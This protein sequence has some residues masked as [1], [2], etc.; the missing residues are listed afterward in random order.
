VYCLTTVSIPC[1]RPWVRERGFFND[2]VSPKRLQTEQAGPGGFMDCATRSPNGAPPAPEL[3][4]LGRAQIE[5]GNGF[6]EFPT[7]AF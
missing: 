4:W 1:T 2:V 5:P 3:L 7:S 6:R